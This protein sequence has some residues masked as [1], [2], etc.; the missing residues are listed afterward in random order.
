M[1]KVPRFWIAAGVYSFL[2]L[3]CFA[4]AMLKTPGQD[5]HMYCGGAVLMAQG[6]TIY[7]DFSYV[8]QLPYHPLIC[9]VLYR[10]LPS[11]NYL[12]IGRLFSVVC[13]LGIILTISWIFRLVFRQCQLDGTYAGLMA[14][15]IYL[16]N[17]YVD[18]A[19][20]YA[21]NHDAVM[22]CVL[23]AFAIWLTIGPNRNSYLKLFSIGSLLTLAT[24]MRAT[25]ILPAVAIGLA[26]FLLP[27]ANRRMRVYRVVSF[28]VGVGL[29]SAWPL[30]LLIRFPEQVY[31]NI[32]RIPKLCG[33]WIQEADLGAYKFRIILDAISSPEYIATIALAIGMLVI[34][35]QQKTKHQHTIH[36]KYA[37]L[38]AWILVLLFA[39]IMIIP[40]Q[41][42]YQYIALPVPFLVIASAWP[43]A[44]LI[45][46][47]KDR[48]P[49]KTAKSIISRL[50]SPY[51]ALAVV[52]CIAVLYNPYVIFRLLWLPDYQTW[53]PIHMRHIAE[54]FGRQITQPGKIMTLDPLLALQIDRPIYNELL[55][56]TFVLPI[57]D[58]LTPHQRE[59]TH[60]AAFSDIDTLLEQDPPAAIITGIA[61]DTLE[62]EL[63][64]HA[65][66]S[67]WKAI[68]SPENEDQDYVLLVP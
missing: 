44:Y 38:L 51:P 34:Y 49:Q 47:R 20:G 60:I 68:R 54:S 37:F 6:E 21:W 53:T 35:S 42:W 50:L 24:M 11:S 31:L 25:T 56:G 15:A 19:N 17:R 43:A 33:A 32:Y 52:L 59:I 5:E 30:S 65:T 16:F 57:A 4:N 9:S 63:V 26:S 46:E 45:R 36:A 55:T 40:P 41:M 22:F 39:I 14:A 10:M 66:N 8:S 3:L 7:K 58:Q 27:C 64:R 18:Y 28:A 23:I 13:D 67:T 61:H 1:N 12:L 62:T 48:T 29:L 2:A